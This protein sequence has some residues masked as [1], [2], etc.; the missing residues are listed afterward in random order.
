MQAEKRV[1]DAFQAEQFDV[2]ACWKTGGRE[3]F[4]LSGALAS[5]ELCE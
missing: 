2:Y 3:P 5:A 1:W 4:A